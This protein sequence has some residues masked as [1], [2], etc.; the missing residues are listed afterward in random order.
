MRSVVTN[1]ALKGQFDSTIIEGIAEYVRQRNYG[2]IASRALCSSASFQ[3]TTPETSC[4]VSD[5]RLRPTSSIWWS[6]WAELG[7]RD[8]R[9][10][11]G[12][13]SFREP[14]CYVLPVDREGTGVTVRVNS[15]YLTLLS[16]LAHPRSQTLAR[17]YGPQFMITNQV[18][19]EFASKGC[20]TIVT[21]TLGINAN[22]NAA[23]NSSVPAPLSAQSIGDAGIW[24]LRSRLGLIGEALPASTS[25]AASATNVTSRTNPNP[26]AAIA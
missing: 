10:Q 23:A 4:T 22:A 2:T 9:S 11:T 12:G 5:P 14:T 15:R 16:T 24:R 6:C 1:P 21:T 25:Y 18:A 17:T 20:P 8:H 7:W 26:V 3:R 13:S 19:L